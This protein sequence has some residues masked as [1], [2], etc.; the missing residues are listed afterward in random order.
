MSNFTT[1]RIQKLLSQAKIRPAVNQVELNLRC[2]QPELLAWSKSNDILLEAYSPLGSTG[3]PQLEDPVVQEIAKAHKV[4]AAN[5]LISWQVQRGCVV[6]PKS[7]TE[8]RI[9][10]NFKGQA[11]FT[12]RVSGIADQCIPCSADVV[13]TD[14]EVQRLEERAKELGETRT[15]DPSESWGVNI[16]KDEQPSKL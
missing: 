15:V 5:V 13:L 7:V 10:S 1:G 12:L 3:A 2:A 11:S 8:S 9:I 16:F 4:D 6:L 14:S